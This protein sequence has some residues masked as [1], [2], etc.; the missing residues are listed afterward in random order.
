[1][2]D[3][4]LPGLVLVQLFPDKHEVSDLQVLLDG[5]LLGLGLE[6]F[7]VFALFLSV[8]LRFTLF[9]LLDREKAAEASLWQ[10]QLL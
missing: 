10:L 7:L 6:L 1:V 4:E 5:L 9:M 2:D 3:V 8:V